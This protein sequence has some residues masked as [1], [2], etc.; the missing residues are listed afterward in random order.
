MQC[1]QLRLSN[2]KKM[3]FFFESLVEQKTL[4]FTEAV[5]EE[6]LLKL[7]WQ[8]C[9]FVETSGLPF[10]KDLIKLGSPGSCAPKS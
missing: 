4:E 5:Y 2:E 3:E 8:P 7:N 10:L 9:Q 6:V 1:K